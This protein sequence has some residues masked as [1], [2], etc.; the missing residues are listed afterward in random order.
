MAKLVQARRFIVSVGWILEECVLI[1][2]LPQRDKAGKTVTAPSAGG[3]KGLL[4]PELAV[5]RSED[6]S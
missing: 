4:W 6:E 1:M 5:L 3:V 2:S